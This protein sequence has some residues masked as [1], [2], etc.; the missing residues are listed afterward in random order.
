[1]QERGRGI[2]G[3]FEVERGVSHRSRLGGGNVQ[4]GA[5]QKEELS[6]TGMN[7]PEEDLQTYAHGA[8]RR[9]DD[10]PSNELCFGNQ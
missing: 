8:K 3:V 5:A 4:T 2:K 6:R 10:R 1:M 9:H 7:H